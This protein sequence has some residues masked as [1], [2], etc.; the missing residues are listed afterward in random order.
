MRKTLS[1]RKSNRDR[2]PKIVYLVG[3]LA[4]GAWGAWAYLL[5]YRSP[6]ELV[7]RLFFILAFCAAIFLTALF[8]FYQIGKAATGKAAE[9]V[10]YP[11]ARRAIFVSFFFLATALMRLVGIFS[12]LNAGLLALILL[13]TEIW[14]STR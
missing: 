3:F 2:T 5:I 9:I 8:L 10:F 12:W 11:A 7:H 14:K 13:L 6:D 1:A 4:Y